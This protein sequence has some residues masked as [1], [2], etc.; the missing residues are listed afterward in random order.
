[1]KSYFSAG[2]NLL[3]E[4]ACPKGTRTLSNYYYHYDDYLYYHHYLHYKARY[5]ARTYYIVAREMKKLHLY[6]GF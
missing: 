1:M 3:F 4:S 5:K 2:E 6:G